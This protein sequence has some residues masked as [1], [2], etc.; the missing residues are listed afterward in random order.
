MTVKIKVVA[1]ETKKAKIVIE[2]HPLEKVF[3]RMT[4]A[5]IADHI[6]KNVND[7]AAIKSVLGWLVM[8]FLLMRRKP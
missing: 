7:I 4:V 2:K 6:D 3:G 8:G 5:E 1:S